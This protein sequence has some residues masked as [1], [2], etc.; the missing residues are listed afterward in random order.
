MPIDTDL[1]KGRAVSRLIDND[2]GCPS[3]PLRHR[4]AA[5][6]IANALSLERAIVRADAVAFLREFNDAVRHDGLSLI[7]AFERGDDIGAA[8]RA[9]DRKAEEVATEQLSHETTCAH[10]SPRCPGCD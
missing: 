4:C 9:E 3:D 2:T 8:S 7:A 10:G 6:R 1:V 5:V